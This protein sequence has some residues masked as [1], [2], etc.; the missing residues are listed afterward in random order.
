MPKLPSG[1]LPAAAILIGVGLPLL[2]AT[3]VVAL[4][5]E[6][7]P[8]LVVAVLAFLGSGVHLGLQATGRS[9]ETILALFAP[10]AILFAMFAWNAA[11]WMLLGVP[12][13]ALVGSVAGVMLGSRH[14]RSRGASPTTS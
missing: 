13:M 1:R 5:L 3:A 14:Q 7:L 4:R 11:S 10:C 2:L 6:Y 9:W 12:A 8:T